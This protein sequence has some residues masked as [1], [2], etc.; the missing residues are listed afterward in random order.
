MVVGVPMYDLIVVGAREKN[1]TE[2]GAGAAYI[3]ERDHGGAN[4][5]GEVANLVATD[6]INDA[7]ILQ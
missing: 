1:G 3:F 4:A 5:W 7:I 6:A 2:T